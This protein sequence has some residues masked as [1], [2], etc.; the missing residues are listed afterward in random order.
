ML[1]NVFQNHLIEQ[2]GNRIEVGRKGIRPDAQRFKGNGATTREGIHDQRARAGRAAKRL[3]RRQ[4][5]HTASG[6]EFGDGGII[7]IREVGDEIEERAAQLQGV[8]E[9]LRILAGSFKPFAA[10]G[11]QK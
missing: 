4:R 3:M 7:P 8:I 1:G 5:E 9:E 2:D 6:E 11:A 10:L